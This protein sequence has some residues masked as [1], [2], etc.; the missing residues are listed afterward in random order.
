MPK[1]D[2]KILEAAIKL[3]ED[4][5]AFYLKASKQAKNIP[6]K[7]L[8]TSLADEELKHIERIT[9]IH[10]GL[11][12]NKNWSDFKKSISKEAKARMRLV[13]KPL[14][15]SE[16]KRVKA[17]PANLEAIKLAM[18]KEK[19]SYNFYNEQEK[20][21]GLPV[22]KILYARLKKEEEHHYD[23]LEE[24]YSLLTDTAS[25]FVKQEGRVMEGG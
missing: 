18:K 21:T 2:L 1:S 12:E 9:E 15:K 5:R 14:S 23:L 20:T 10:D 25:W 24:A 7:R 17:D 13:F 16:R 8:L 22:A 11:I 3:E 4:G 19:L 6:A